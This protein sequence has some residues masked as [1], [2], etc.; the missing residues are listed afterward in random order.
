MIKTILALFLAFTLFA[1]N[2]KK[3]ES[4]SPQKPTN[5]WIEGTITNGGNHKIRLIATT[6]NGIID[7]GNS[8]IDKNGNFKIEGNI[9]GM[10]IYQI[11][12][13]TSETKVIP[14]PLDL[15]DKVVLKGNYETIERLPQLSGPTWAPRV[16]QFFQHFNDFANAQ[17]PIFFDKSLSDNQKMEKLLQLKAPL[18]EFVR[19]SITKDPSNISNLLFVSTITP[20]SGFENWDTTNLQP[21]KLMTDA[22]A[23]KYPQSVFTRSLQAQYEQIVKGYNDYQQFQANGG[24]TD[25][26][27]KAF[28][29]IALPNPQ[30]KIMKLSSLRGKY[31]LVDFW[32]SWCPPCRRENPNVVA[33]YQEFHN[34]GKG[35]EVFSVSL[36]KD[37]VAWE[38]AIAQDHL[39]WKYHVSDLKYW[40]SSV[41][42]QFGL[43]SIPYNFLIDPTG[44]VIASNL[45]GPQLIQKLREVLK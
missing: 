19:Q 30:G 38:K 36:D 5:V 39:I 42:S 18:D 27:S 8:D 35:F 7:L 25:P 28:P 26:F 6:Q 32:A 13:D 45:R 33:A 10:G 21:I 37:K 2:S 11:Q 41:V 17:Q 4:T 15:Q 29:D 43:E 12:F 3:E 16:T 1:C 22:F 44:K 40:E 14:I 31:V 23:Q 24:K 9:N 20:N 34:K